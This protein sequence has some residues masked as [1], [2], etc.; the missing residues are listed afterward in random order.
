MAK[1]ALAQTRW[2]CGLGG[3]TAQHPES[4]C[5]EETMRE[6]LKPGNPFPE[7]E[8]AIAYGEVVSLSKLMAGM[9]TVLTFN[10]GNF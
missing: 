9:P 8:L 7:F 10:R 5:V 2:K 4:D 3:G 6:D 1:R